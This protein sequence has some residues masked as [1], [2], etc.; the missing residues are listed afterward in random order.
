MTRP[1]GL[2][3]ACLRGAIHDLRG[4]MNTISILHEIL[5]ESPLAAAAPQQD[6]LAGTSKALRQLDGMLQRL[7]AAAASLAPELRPVA[8]APQLAAAVQSAGDDDVALQHEPGDHDGVVVLSCAE[9]LPLL[10]ESLLRCGRAAVADGSRLRLQ[11]RIDGDRAVV[12]L[13][14]NGPTTALPAMPSAAQLTAD[15]PD[16]FTFASRAVGL[17]AELD[18]STTTDGFQL[19]V[20]LPLAGRPTTGQVPPC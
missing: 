10:L 18:V 16:W 19:L 11:G 17:D 20:R 15:E 5:R 4:A 3:T 1:S 6:A 12:A 13:A 14:G 9:R 7:H 8:L 2:A